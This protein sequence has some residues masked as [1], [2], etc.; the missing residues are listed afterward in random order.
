MVSAEQ[1]SRSIETLRSARR[2]KGASDRNLIDT[3][4][5]ALFRACQADNEKNGSSS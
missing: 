4:V 2:F 1:E 3:A 5:A